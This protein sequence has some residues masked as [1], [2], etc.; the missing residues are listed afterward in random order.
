M[1]TPSVTTTE[2][3][4][5]VSCSLSAEVPVDGAAQGGP[6]SSGF[7]SASSDQEGP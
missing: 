4:D 5:V 3:S 6:E 7:S 1:E 2:F